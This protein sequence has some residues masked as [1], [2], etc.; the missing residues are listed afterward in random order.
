MG[1]GWPTIVSTI[2][3]TLALTEASYRWIE[4][5]VRTVGFRATWGKI[6]SSFGGSWARLPLPIAASLGALIIFAFACYGIATAPDKSQEQI[7][8]EAGERLIAAQTTAGKAGSQ[9]PGPNNGGASNKDQP[10]SAGPAWPPDQPM[11]DGDQ[12]VGFG[13]SVMSGCAAALYERFPGI[14]LDAKPIRQWHDAPA[15]VQA[16]IDNGTVRNV[17]VLNFGTNAGFKEPEA[18]AA[19]RSILAML[20]PGRRVV[21]INTVGVSYWVP[22]TNET[23]RSISADY[24]NTIVADW[25]SVVQ[26][27]PGLLHRDK[28]HPN[29]SG[30]VIYAETIAKAIEKLGPGQ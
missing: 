6:R 9:E 2:V 18:E 26:S 17:V 22:S 20:G 16:M 27:K 25:Y 29:E 13:D 1:P 23:L 14:L 19:L 28:T 12:I 10:K 11:P 8:I 21:L 15:L 5:P 3:L 4:M 7:A 30:A 24:P